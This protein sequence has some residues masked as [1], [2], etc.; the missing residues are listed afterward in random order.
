MT[1]A[2]FSSACIRLLGCRTPISVAL[3]VVVPAAGVD[4][5]PGADPDTTI[6]S[7]RIG[8]TVTV[9]TPPSFIRSISTGFM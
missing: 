8:W 6:A 7:L 3:S 9:S 2:T 4:S 1:P 5:M